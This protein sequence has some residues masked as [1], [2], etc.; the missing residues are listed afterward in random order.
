MDGR[1]DDEPWSRAV[2]VSDF[3]Q[4]GDKTA[5]PE[6][7]SVRVMYDRDAFFFGVEAKVEHGW[8]KLLAEQTVR[9]GDVYA[10]DSIEFFV[11]APNG[12]YYQVVVNTLGT[13][14]DARGFDKTF[15]CQATAA[16]QVDEDRYTI[17]L[18]FPVAPMGVPEIEPGAAWRLHVSRNC[19]NLQPPQTAVGISLDGVSPHDIGN[20]R[21]AEMEQ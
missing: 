18:R 14:Y 10:D 6:E 21:Y 12:E 8:G 11:Y 1:L 4:M 17:E 5:P 19:M 9:D 20:Y 15:D 2:P 13:I 3:L 16:V 7:T